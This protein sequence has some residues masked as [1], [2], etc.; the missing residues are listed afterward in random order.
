MYLS[1]HLVM[2]PVILPLYQNRAFTYC[3]THF[4]TQSTLTFS[5]SLGC[6][7][8]YCAFL[9]VC[10]CAAIISDSVFLFILQSLLAIAIIFHCNFFS[11]VK[12]LPMKLHLFQHITL[13]ISSPFL[14]FFNACCS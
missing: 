12:E 10:F 8:L 1:A 11:L 5:L 3:F 13:L 7:C 6:F 14:K 2:P 4:I 9:V